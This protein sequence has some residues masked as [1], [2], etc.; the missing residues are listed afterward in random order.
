MYNYQSEARGMRDSVFLKD[1]DEQKSEETGCCGRCC[2]CLSIDYYQ[3]YF[4]VD[5]EI[6]KNRIMLDLK[7]WSGGFFADLKADYDV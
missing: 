3:D 6:V 5:N 7:F 1:S 4:K 2:K